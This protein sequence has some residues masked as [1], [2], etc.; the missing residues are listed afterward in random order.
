MITMKE[1]EKIGEIRRRHR[2]VY[3]PHGNHLQVREDVQT[4]LTHI[5]ALIQNADKLNDKKKVG[6]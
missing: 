1:L 6:K 5:D 2:A 4:L 3:T